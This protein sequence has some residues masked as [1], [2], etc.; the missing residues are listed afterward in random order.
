MCK[1]SIIIPVYGQWDLVKRNID[2]LLRHDSTNINEVLIVDDCSPE[3]NPY[4]FN[5]SI[6][7][8]IKNKNNLGYS[9]TINKGLVRANSEIIIL[10]DSDAYPIGPF[11]QILT[12]I[13]EN[14]PT[15][16]CVGFG[17]VDDEGVDTGNFQFEPSVIGFILGQLLQSKL[18]RLQFRQNN[19]LLINSCAVSFRKACIKDVGYFDDITFPVLEADVDVCL[20]I[21]SSNWKLM[22][23]KDITICH[24]GGNSYKVDYK[25]VLLY[26]KS[27]WKL[28]RKHNAISSPTF[29]KVLLKG[30]IMLEIFAFKILS[31]IKINGQI[32]DEKIKGRQI[33]LKEVEF[34]S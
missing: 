18:E 10:L 31:V 3:P 33:L 23:T 16:G 28:L 9:G 11:I 26:H 2:S 34:Y 24:K 6:V 20:K 5:N 7:Q 15:V 29:V 19:Y 27:R 14:D 21:H 1:V 22:F 12:K 32:Y 17:T 30:R 25:R 8:I 13:Y 4:D